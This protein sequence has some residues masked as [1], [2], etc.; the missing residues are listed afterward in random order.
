ML[1]RSILLVGVILLLDQ[2]LKIYIKTNYSL[3][4]DE[5][6]LGSF[7]RLHFIENN[8]MAFG[9]QFGGQTG[10]IILSVIR[11]IAVGVIGY[12]LYKAINKN[13]N[14][15][16]IYSLCFILA[17]AMGNIIDSAFY[18]MIFSESGFHTVAQAF[19]DGGG[20]AGFLQ[21]KVVDMFYAPVINTVWP[22]WVPFVGGSELVFFR[23][24][25]NIADSSITIGVIILLLFYNRIFPK[26]KLAETELLPD[27]TIQNENI[28][29]NDTSETKE[30]ESVPTPEIHE[31]TEERN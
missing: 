11:I 26:H 31:M 4:Q 30:V 25:F 7:F 5:P 3:G 24:I 13:E 29:L 15:L 10:K 6:L 19:P 16:L 8:G 21:G 14:K 2:L 23:P 27:Q 28:I 18:G 12:I 20:Y 1:K 22:Q 17:G 9:M